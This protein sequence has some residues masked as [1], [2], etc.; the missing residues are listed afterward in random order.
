MMQTY[1]QKSL[2]FQKSKYILYLEFFVALETN[3]F[4]VFSR[5]KMLI[6]PMILGDNLKSYFFRSI[7]VLNMR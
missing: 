4:R 2:V 6:L 3:N 5:K 1:V 7:H